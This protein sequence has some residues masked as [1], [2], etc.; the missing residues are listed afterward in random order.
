MFYNDVYIFKP[1]TSRLANSEKYV[2]CKDFKF[3][4]SSKYVT[5]F[6]NI[7]R[8]LTISGNDYLVKIL[9]NP[10]PLFYIYRVDEITNV[11]CQFQMSIILATINLIKE[12]RLIDNKQKIN[13][14]I[15]G[16]VSK[17]TQWCINNNVSYNKIKAF[18]LF[19]RCLSKIT[20]NFYLQVFL[21][22]LC[23][24]LHRIGEGLNPNIKGC[25]VL[26]E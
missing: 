1:Q 8:R 18:C 9:K 26:P 23:I 19:V 17:C 13:E 5:T 22:P 20:F 7:I 24:R 12:S 21:F 16:N 4:S 11:L 6:G 3:S 10:I 14:L 25:W 15:K 2:I